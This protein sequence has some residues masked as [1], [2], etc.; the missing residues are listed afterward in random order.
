MSFT[1]PFTYLNDQE[2]ESEFAKSVKNEISFSQFNEYLPLSLN[3][4]ENSE[5]GWSNA[6]RAVRR[7][8]K[9]TSVSLG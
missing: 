3:V 6:V 9:T 2:N 1:T 4:V 8:N 5:S 7:E